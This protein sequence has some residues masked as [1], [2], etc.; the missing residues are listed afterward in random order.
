MSRLVGSTDQQYLSEMCQAISAGTCSPDLVARS[1]E[2]FVHS[3][4]L[5]TAHC[6]LRLY[7]CS[8]DPSDYLKILVTFIMK[9]FGPVWFHVK[10]QYSCAEGSKHLW[11]MI[12]FSRYLLPDLR[13]IVDK[14]IQR[15]GYYAV[16]KTFFYVC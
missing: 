10:I 4:W 5:T 13:A 12:K 7:V 11:R 1:P 2:P 9:V 3:K 14:V 15:N 8:D 16:L 6:I